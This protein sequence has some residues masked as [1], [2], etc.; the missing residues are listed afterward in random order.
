MLVHCVWGGTQWCLRRRREQLDRAS[1]QLG[2][3]LT[4]CVVGM[5]PEKAAR[6]RPDLCWK[7]QL[8][9]GSRGRG[10]C[11]WT[12][13]ACS[14][15]WALWPARQDQQLRGGLWCGCELVV[16]FGGVGAEEGGGACILGVGSDGM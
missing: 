6:K 12:G 2:A 8:G 9:K 7:H 11:A 1:S 13:A 5:G 3:V 15:G 10:T 4:F 16:G 14:D